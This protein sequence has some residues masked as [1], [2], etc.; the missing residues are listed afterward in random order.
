M[1]SGD[2]DVLR[3]DVA[4]DDAARMRVAQRLTYVAHDACCILHRELSRSTEPGAHILALDER[5][6]VVEQRSFRRRR[7]E[8]NDVWMVEARGELNLPAKPL[9]VHSGGEIRRQNLYDYLPLELRFRGDEHARHPAARQ[10]P[11]D[12][13]RRPN[14][15]LKLLLKV[16]GQAGWLAESR[17]GDCGIRNQARYRML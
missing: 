10:L 11:V 5:H 8:W 1:I 12:A 16:G 6:R 9:S 4:V 14:G 7:K 17:D 15:F 2:D 3:L 13:V